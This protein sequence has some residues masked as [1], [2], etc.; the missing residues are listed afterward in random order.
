MGTVY[1]LRKD[2]I[3]GLMGFSSHTTEFIFYHP[4][5]GS[6]R[7]IREHRGHRA[8]QPYS[9]H[10]FSMSSVFSSA[11][12]GLT[13]SFST[14]DGAEMLAEAAH[15]GKTAS[16]GVIRAGRR[17]AASPA[18]EWIVGLQAVAPPFGVVQIPL[19][20]AAQAARKG[21]AGLPL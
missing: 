7:I 12:G 15:Y 21:G 5:S 18:L 3:C 11:A 2:P 13:H 17:G 8:S 20:G 14:P 4:F 1:V 10:F 6:C 9:F 16:L 19:H